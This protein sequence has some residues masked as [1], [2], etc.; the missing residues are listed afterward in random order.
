[1]LGF[2]RREHLFALGIFAVVATLFF[3]PLLQGQTFS[4]VAGRQQMIFPWAGGPIPTNQ[5][6]TVLHYDQDESLYPWQVFMSRQLRSGSFPLWNPYSFGGAPF[7]AN[8]QNG[9]LYPPRL[10]LSYSVSPPRVHDLL[11]VTHL[12]MAGVVM[13]LLLGAVGLSF[14]AAIVGALAWMLNTFGLSWQALEHYVVIEVGLPLGVLLAHLAVKRRSWEAALGV[15]GVLSLLFIGGNVLFAELAALAILGYG[16]ALGIADAGRNWRALLRTSALLAAAVALSGGLAAV[17]ILPTVALASE[18]ARVSLS[19]DELGKFALSWGDLQYLFRWPPDPF[20]RDPYHWD[21]FAGT[22]VGLLALVGSA[23]RALLPRF[24]LCV[25]VLALLFMLH[26][27][28]TYVASELLPGFGNFKPLSRAAFLLQFALAVLA[29]YGL[30]TA[31][32]RV[33]T[34]RRRRLGRLSS[35]AVLAV[36]VAFSIVGQEWL[37]KRNVM[38]HQPASQRYLYPPT[39]LIG[40]LASTPE[41]RFLPTY[42]EFRGSTAMIDGLQSVGGYESLLPARTQ[43]FWRVLG[44]RLS[45]EDL[46]SEPLIYAYTPAFELSRLQPGLLARASVAHVVAPPPYI[47]LPQVPQGLA[48]L[49]G[50]SD[51]RIFAVLGALPHAYVVGGCEELSS[52]FAALARFISDDFDPSRKVILE[53]AFMRRAGL[54]CSGSQ[55][56][57]SGT[58][59]ILRRSVNSLLVL[60]R[61]SRSSWLVVADSW[62]E[63]WRVTVDGRDADVLPADSALRAV[64]LPRGDHLVRFTYVP[65]SFVAGAIISSLSVGILAGGAILMLWRRRQALRALVTD[66]R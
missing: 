51:G 8:G 56:G 41:A 19:Y 53:Q 7:F 22:A 58:A 43:N 1:V 66:R 34:S 65:P 42:P 46:A 31:L 17:S 21:L 49:H 24:A 33:E 35:A 60:A 64:Q 12:F 47:G 55:S 4:D 20:K 27:P 2:T 9:V 13:F 54:S 52:P 16:V 23:R 61:A 15:G 44:D 6:E 45:P 18:T 38:P 5:L 57:R 26:T 40:E 30:E 10:L 48:L 36:A 39:P 37:W 3:L 28:V 32:R 14:P 50:G 62:D 29:A 25:G 11:L 59:S 63:G